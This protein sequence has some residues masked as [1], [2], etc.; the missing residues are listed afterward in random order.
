VKRC[1]SAAR[2]QTQQVLTLSGY[3]LLANGLGCRMSAIASTEFRLH[4]DGLNGQLAINPV[5]TRNPC[6][7]VRRETRWRSTIEPQLLHIIFF[8]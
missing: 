6:E 4:F 7:G 8:R 3:E 5:I 2:A 1:G